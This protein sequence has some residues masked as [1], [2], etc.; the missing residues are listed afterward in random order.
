MPTVI[1][2][3]GNVNSVQIALASQ[4]QAEAGTDNATLMTP[5]RNLQAG[6][7]APHA[8]L[9]DQQASGVAGPSPGAGAVWVNRRLNTEVRD[10]TGFVTLTANQFVVTAAGWCEWELVQRDTYS[11]R[12]YNVTDA[13]VVGYGMSLNTGTGGGMNLTG[14]GGGALIAGKTYEIQFNAATLA[15]SPASRGTEVYTRVKLWRT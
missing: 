14:T 13:V 9:E 15:A 7:G 6:L 1:D 11:S 5:L 8:I 10:P 4:A 2:G 3:S 12:L